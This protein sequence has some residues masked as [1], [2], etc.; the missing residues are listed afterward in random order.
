M[1]NLSGTTVVG[2]RVL[3]LCLLAVAG[4]GEQASTPDAAAP[5]SQSAAADVDR[6]KF[7]LATE[8][9]GAGDVIAVREQAGDGDDIVI[10]GRIGGSENPWIDGRAA[11]SIVDSSLKACSDIP[12]D[13][14]PKPWD[15][16]CE[17]PK[18]PT[19]T[20]LVKVV[21]DS[22]D[23]VGT[24]ARDLLPLKELST[25]VVKGTAQRDD[26]GNLTVLASG[27]FVKQQ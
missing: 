4:C 27:V 8:P 7:L 24:D 1:E 14:C 9:N 10:T 20:A 2:L 26:A 25:V 12:G 22:G 5:S 18:L 11:F 15:Y 6:A 21:D 3:A 23:L 17:T 19:A 13:S 16:C